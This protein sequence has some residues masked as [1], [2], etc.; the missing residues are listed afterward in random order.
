MAD[1]GGITALVGCASSGV[2]IGAFTES[3]KARGVLMISPSSTS[4]LITPLEDDGLLWR[5]APSDA[6]QGVAVAELLR[7]R[8]DQKV[9]VINRDD[10]YGNSLRNVMQDVI[11][12]DLDCADDDVYVSSAYQEAQQSAELAEAL[13]RIEDL[14]PSAVVA[15]G[16]VDDV[17][18][19]LNIAGDSAVAEKTFILPDGAKDVA[20][21]QRVQN[22]ALLGRIVGTNPA[23]PDNRNSRTFTI[24]YRGKWN[25]E[26]VSFAAHAY[27]A[28]YLLAY[29]LGGAGGEMVSGAQ[30]AEQLR[31]LSQG[32]EVDVGPADFATS[33]Q[34]LASDS[35]ATINFSGASGALDFDPT[36][37]EALGDIEG[38]AFDLDEEEIVSLGVI[39]DSFQSNFIP[40]EALQALHTSTVTGGA[41]G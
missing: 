38:W 11:C 7:W 35:N 34:R 36:T 28:A 12:E 20:L 31:R 22:R 24:N 17:S 29:A 33:V 10:A 6:V 3:A 39:F 5:T 13:V 41:G 19:F 25:E 16:F 18:F 8:G 1:V 2:T 15:I 37:G 26:P 27:D 21:L 30:L 40:T 23:S 14:D 32:A 4:A 9:A